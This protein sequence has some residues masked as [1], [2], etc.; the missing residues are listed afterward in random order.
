MYIHTHTHTHT[1]TPREHHSMTLYVALSQFFTRCI[2]F[3]CQGLF[4]YLA[5]TAS[6]V[7]ELWEKETGGPKTESAGVLELPSE[8]LA[9]APGHKQR[10]M[11]G[12]HFHIGNAAC[13]ECITDSVQRE[14]VWRERFRVCYSA[15]CVD[16]GTQGDSWRSQHEGLLGSTCREHLMEGDDRTDSGVHRENKEWGNKKCR[17]GER[18]QSSVYRDSHHIPRTFQTG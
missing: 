3:Q 18:R 12:K 9:E 14:H 17:L 6:N 10:E 13:R 2:V 11:Q 1:H 5:G 16:Q 7:K 8:A 15:E 4:I